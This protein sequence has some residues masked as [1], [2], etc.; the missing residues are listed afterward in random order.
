LYRRSRIIQL[1]TARKMAASVPGY[2]ETQWSAWVA[3]L[4]SRVSNTMSFA[5]FFFP[6]MIRCAWGLK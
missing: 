2:G 3:V 6:S 4:D 5:P 1:A